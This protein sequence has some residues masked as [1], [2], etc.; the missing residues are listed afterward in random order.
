MRSLSARGRS[1]TGVV[2]LALGVGLGGCAPDIEEPNI[3]I[4]GV[5]GGSIGLD[6]GTLRLLVRVDN[7][8]DFVLEAARV[9][10]DLDIRRG[11]DWFDLADGELERGLTVPALGSSSLE[12]P[13]EFRLGDAI[14]VGAELLRGGNPRFRV[15]GHVD[16]R[17]PIR[18]R[19]PYR[20]EITADLGDRARGEP[21]Q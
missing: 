19:V 20:E 10:Y 18:R 13:V 3:E 15:A 16:L 6:G 8:N 21:R 5:R 11:E 12:I 9:D 2:A 17:R 14:E 4:V 7:P 1:A